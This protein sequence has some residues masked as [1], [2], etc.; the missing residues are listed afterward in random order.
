[1]A[2]YRKKP[3]LIEAFRMG[4]DTWPD[5]F[6]EEVNQNNITTHRIGEIGQGLSPF[7]HSK[8]H[9]KIKT[10]EGETT[11]NYGDYIIKGIQGEVYSCKPDIF[12]QT[13]N[14]VSKEK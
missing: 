6:T 14:L 12:E 4:I 1:M 7:D 9:C 2:K 13:Y 5:W 8:I 10:P 3:V 11:G